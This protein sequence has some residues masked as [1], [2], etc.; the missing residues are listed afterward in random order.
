M[1][2]ITTTHGGHYGKNMMDPGAVGN[3]YK[4]AVLVQEI[5]KT[6]ISATGAKDA[7]D[8]S[9]TN[10]NQNLANIVSNMDRYAGSNDW[11]ISHHF[12]AFNGKATGVE[13]WYYAGD[14]QA[15]IVATNLSKAIASA[16]GITNRGAKATTDL[17]V[18]RNSKGH[19]LL[20]EWCF[21]DNAADMKAWNANKTKAINA[22]LQV[23]GYKEGGTSTPSTPNTSNSNKITGSKYKVVKGDTLYSI[24]KRS[25][26]SV[27]NLK[28]WNGLKSDLIK[29]GQ[30]LKLTKPSTSK[31]VK[32]GSTIKFHSYATHYQTGQK[33]PD[34]V[35][36]KSYKV[37]EIEKLP[38]KQSRSNYR[39]LLDGIMSWVLGQDIYGV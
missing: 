26:V 11:N 18:I 29:P 4:E 17:Y 1:V 21:I 23:L 33:I 10:V 20:I 39:Y 30:T 9:A 3:G 34:W 32:V 22:A 25:G 14:N 28:S 2:K 27:A 24:S 15:K 36:K 6:F 19:T 13:V 35:K 37:L 16:L 5:N 38:K 8:F 12:N 7:S 31:Q